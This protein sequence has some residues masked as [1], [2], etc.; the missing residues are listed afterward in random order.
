MASNSN[1]S[2]TFYPEFSENVILYRGADKVFIGDGT[3]G[4]VDGHL[5]TQFVDEVEKDLGPVSA[6]ALAVSQGYQGTLAE[7]SLEIARA[8]INAQE[9]KDARDTAIEMK[10]LAVQAKEG[11]VQ[12]Q[13]TAEAWA[14]GTLGGTPSATNNAAYY[15]IQAAQAKQDAIDQANRASAWAT[16]G[17]TGDP[18]ATNNSQYYA[19]Q[20]SD[21]ADE[22]HAWANGGSNG[23]PDS[24][25]NAK[26]YADQAH[27]W[28][29]GAL[30]DNGIG[31][32]ANNAKYYAEQAQYWATGG[33]TGTPGISNNAKYYADEAKTMR[34]QTLEKFD[35][36]VAYASQVSQDTQTVS[37]L[38]DEAEMWATGG[39]SGTPSATNNAKYYAETA[40]Q[41]AK[42]W[43]VGPGDDT[44]DE[45]YEN[46]AKHYAETAYEN[47]MK[48]AIGPDGDTTDETYENNAKHYS[49]LAKSYS[50]NV[51]SVTA[52]TL[53]YNTSGNGTVPPE[54]GDGWVGAPAPQE[55]KYLWSKTTFTWADGTSKVVY[56]V[57]FI[58]ANGT[59]A[60]RQVNGQA[61]DVS[62][63]AT[64]LMYDDSLEDVA[65][66]ETIKGHIDQL[67]INLQA[68]ADAAGSVKDVNGVSPV[69]GTV[70]LDADDIYFDKDEEVKEGETRQSLK[71]YISTIE[72]VYATDAQILALFE[73]EG[74]G[75]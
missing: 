54:D 7:W 64:N 50:D 18:S 29:T 32:A 57:G 40:N 59:G 24:T 16:G 74:V 12:A 42:K 31:G 60:V 33:S 5:Y 52:T 22:A 66:K 20:A 6:Y 21:S 35:P 69:N 75:A 49:D 47:A 39:S 72:P 58:G 67:E 62:L 10:G 61:G 53:Y 14:A 63:D 48:W 11:A 41:Q 25:N 9:A 55:G 46:N 30:N 13:N 73:E 51:E 34:D 3:N 37:D 43:A 23:T 45:T 70:T 4:H 27:V 68:Y 17:L 36:I 26:Y 71:D 8:S 56:N 44:T 65:Q 15:A 1:G 28:T 2:Y 38:T 19:G